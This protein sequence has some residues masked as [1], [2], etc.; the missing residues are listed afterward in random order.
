[1]KSL[2][3]KIQEYFEK[4]AMIAVAIFSNPITFIAAFALVIYWIMLHDFRNEK[5]E[6]AIRDI[7]LSITFLSFFIIQKRSEHF[8]TS[9]H[10]KLNELIA[11][12]ENA[13]NKFIKVEEKTEDEMKELSKGHEVKKSNNMAG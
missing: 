6:D 11:A 8:N 1:M 3:K 9:L 2:Y 12:K 5:T 10:I 13:D 4:L 7:I